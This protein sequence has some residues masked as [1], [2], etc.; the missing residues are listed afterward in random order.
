MLSVYNCQGSFFEPI[1]TDHEQVKPVRKRGDMELLGEIARLKR[2]NSEILELLDQL[3]RKQV[4]LENELR[5]QEKLRVEKPITTQAVPPKKESHRLW[6]R[7]G[8]ICRSKRNPDS[9]LPISTS[10]WYRGVKEGRFPPPKKF[11]RMSLWK[12]ADIKRLVE[13]SS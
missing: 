10:N 1:S 5:R 9:L 13:S 11:G 2:I 8:D 6:V 4:L 7:A 3:V 12:L